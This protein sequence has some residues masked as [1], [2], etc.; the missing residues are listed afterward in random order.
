MPVGNGHSKP[1]GI[2]DIFA[3]LHLYTH[4][5]LYKGSVDVVCMKTVQYRRTIVYLIIS[6]IYKVAVQF[7]HITYTVAVLKRNI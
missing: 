4:R 1:N 5:S 2:I 6:S 3:C 7:V